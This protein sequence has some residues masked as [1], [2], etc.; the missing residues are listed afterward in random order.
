MP[1]LNVTDLAH[2]RAKRERKQTARIM[3]KHINDYCTLYAVVHESRDVV[4]ASIDFLCANVETFGSGGF[5]EFNRPM[6]Q[7][8]TYVAC[9]MTVRFPE[10]MEQKP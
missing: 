8:S 4:Q 2:Y 6:R 3:R 5:G 1:T 10:I 9:G 7:G